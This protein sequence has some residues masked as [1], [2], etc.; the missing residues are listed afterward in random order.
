MILIWKLKARHIFR[1]HVLKISVAD[2]GVSVPLKHGVDCLR[3]LSAARF[4]DAARIGPGIHIAIFSGLGACILQFDEVCPLAG[5]AVDH[6]RK[7]N[8]I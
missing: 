6:I 2:L 3:E 8:F 5:R 7:E 1:R 4:V